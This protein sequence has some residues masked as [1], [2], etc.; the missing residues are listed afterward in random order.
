M[1]SEIDR[2]VQQGTTVGIDGAVKYCINC[3]IEFDPALKTGIPIKCEACGN[4][5][6]ARAIA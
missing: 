1:A 4:T 6:V 3:G 5:F 2:T